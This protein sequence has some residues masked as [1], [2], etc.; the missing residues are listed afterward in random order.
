MGTSKKIETWSGITKT[1]RFSVDFYYD[2]EQGL[3]S[4]NVE[5]S[6]P[7]FARALHLPGQAVTRLSQE[8][9]IKLKPNPDFDVLKGTAKV[10]IREHYGEILQLRETKTE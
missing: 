1:H 3:Y 7:P 6:S 2:D 8:R 9:P 5:A 10:T 4:G